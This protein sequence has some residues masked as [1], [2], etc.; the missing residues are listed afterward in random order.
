M[1]SNGPWGEFYKGK[2]QEA[3]FATYKGFDKI[4]LK[5]KIFAKDAILLKA[6]FLIK[7]M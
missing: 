1:A 5:D 6:L 3:E 7:R 4:N 2:V